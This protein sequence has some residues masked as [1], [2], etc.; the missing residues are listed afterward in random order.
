[1]NWRKNER[2]DKLRL[3]ILVAFLL[4]ISIVILYQ[5]DNK[6]NET[7]KREIINNE[8]RI[9]ELNAELLNK[10][11]QNAINDLHFLEGI[12]QF[13]LNNRINITDIEEIWR[14]FSE[15]SQKYDQIRFI[16]VNGNEEIRVNYK[17][18]KSYVCQKKELQNK[19]DRYG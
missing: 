16:D 7:Q 13:Y 2:I 10:D 3:P 11:L 9:T 1:M 6:V 12:Y 5:I 8:K 14:V 4:F 18:R 17:N 15:Q 19:K